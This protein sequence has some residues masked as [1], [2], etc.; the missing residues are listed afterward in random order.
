M[1][2]KVNQPYRQIKG[3]GLDALFGDT[4]TTT[5]ESVAIEAIKLPQQQARR[6]FDPQ[7]F[8]R[9]SQLTASGEPRR[10]MKQALTSLTKNPYPSN[11][12]EREVIHV[13]LGRSK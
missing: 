8:W 7:K 6:Y 2:S 5:G 1:K 4:P 10:G 13:L 9:T 11:T 12:R 3:L